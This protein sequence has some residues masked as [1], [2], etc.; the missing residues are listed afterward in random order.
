MKNKQ[1]G[2]I[3]DYLT[4]WMNWYYGNDPYPNILHNKLTINQLAE[5]CDKKEEIMKIIDR[6]RDSK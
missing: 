2:L 5:V 4:A 6:V 3:Q 1:Q